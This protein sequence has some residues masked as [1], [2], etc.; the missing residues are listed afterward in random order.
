MFLFW[1]T[2][3]T[4]SSR[5]PFYSE[6]A[7]QRPL[8]GSSEVQFTRITATIVLPG[9]RY[10]VV[11]NPGDLCGMAWYDYQGARRAVLLIQRAGE[12]MMHFVP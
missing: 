3:E 4:G 11:L 2:G 5:D 6:G 10:D 7:R 8:L 1:R 12:S 9:L